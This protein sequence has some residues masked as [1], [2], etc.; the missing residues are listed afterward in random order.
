MQDK[1]KID[2]DFLDSAWA[3]MHSQLDEH[4]P[5]QKKRRRGFLY[6]RWS[7]AAALLLLVSLPSYWYLQEYNGVEK[8]DLVSEEASPV[9]STNINSLEQVK[10]EESTNNTQVET[11][12]NATSSP[13]IHERSSR[14]NSSTSNSIATTKDP[15]SKSKTLPLS[16]DTDL[17]KTIQVIKEPKEEIAT[18]DIKAT[19]DSPKVEELDQTLLR[20]IYT[21][22][23][24]PSLEAK[25]LAIEELTKPDLK[26]D[27]PRLAASLYV[28][29]DGFINPTS[30]VISGFGVGIGRQATL[31]GKLKWN[32]G[33][34][35]RFNR[36]YLSATQ[37][38]ARLQTVTDAEF[39]LSDD[40]LVGGS[41]STSVL[42]SVIK[43][44]TIEIPL[45]LSLQT[46]NH[47]QFDAGIAASYALGTYA[48]NIRASADAANGFTPEAQSVFNDLAA[49]S[50]RWYGGNSDTQII[51]ERLN[52][53]RFDADLSINYRLS[54]RWGLQVQGRYNITPPVKREFVELSNTTIG[55]GL[56]YYIK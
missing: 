5:V 30:T 16:L 32:V 22:Q 44:H 10:Q 15:S 45:S 14:P 37:D 51:K 46:G 20:T 48:G 35:Y 36:W 8:V 42:A 43:E 33:L 56:R 2:A 19:P 24:I 12:E 29:A 34:A 4:M 41:N 11:A 18:I 49:A 26:I 55:L 47:W 25:L 39:G 21:S 9:P 7:L 53:I 23:T 6:W 17:P 50:S 54:G 1:E 13:A 3:D 28:E 52:T 31:L 38:Q 40:V 27:R